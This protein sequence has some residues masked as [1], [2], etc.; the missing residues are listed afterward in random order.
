MLWQLIPGETMK[1]KNIQ[2]EEEEEED[3]EEE[4]MDDSDP[5]SPLKLRWVSL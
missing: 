2:E 5:D 3:E 4:D 1:E